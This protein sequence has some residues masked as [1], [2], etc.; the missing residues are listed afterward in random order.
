MVGVQVSRA[1]AFGRFRGSLRQREH[2]QF[3]FLRAHL[4]FYFAWPKIFSFRD[5][6]TSLKQAE[7]RT[8]T[9]ERITE[10]LSPSWTL[11]TLAE[12]SFKEKTSPESFTPWRDWPLPSIRSP[13]SVE[14]AVEPCWRQQRRSIWP[15]NGPPLQLPRRW[16]RELP[17]PDSL[18]SSDSRL[19]STERRE[20][21]R[22]ARKSRHRPLSH[23][24]LRRWSPRKSE[25]SQ[26]L[27][28]IIEHLDLPRMIEKLIDRSRRESASPVKA[29]DALRDPVRGT[30]QR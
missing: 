26:S 28:A 6:N 27:L 7:L 21:S 29:R 18:T 20:A 15:A 3:P 10:R 11:L 23:L 9:S 22:S 4:V 13:F 1:C 24:L 16:L 25:L 17:A 19:W 2:Q 30:Q 12:F 5:T 8:W 14:R